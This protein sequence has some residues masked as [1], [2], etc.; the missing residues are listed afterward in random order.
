MEFI[1]LHV[2][3]NASDG[4][5]TP[6]QVADLALD[7]G[8]RAIALTDH[9][10]IDGISEIMNYTKDKPLEVVPG[11]ELSCYYQNR[12][13]HILGFYVDY[14]NPDLNRELSFLKEAREGRN[15]KMIELMQKDGLPITM[16][17]LL[18]GNPDS[19]ITRA[20]FARVLVEEG[21]C[22]DKEV[23][24][25]KYIGIGC[26]YYLPKPQVT[27][28]TAMHILTTYSKAAFLAHPL[29]YHLG[30]RQIEELLVYL[31]GLGLKGLEAYHSSNNAYESDKLRQIA[32]TL[33]LCISGGSDFHGIIKPNIQLGVGRG[34]M[35]IPYRLLE[36]I[37]TL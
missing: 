15:I 11:I 6:S 34:N 10:T 1:D 5:F 22:K 4:S 8:L 25:R 29:L 18:H 16:E 31:K 33:D 26:K 2:H 14:E 7:A 3:S 24:F 12:E 32:Q 21:I 13:V 19:V 35:R 28:E 27:C 30:Y 36:H 17:K 37:K 9:D 20:H 23:A